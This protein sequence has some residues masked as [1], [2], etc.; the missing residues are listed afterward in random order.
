MLSRHKRAAAVW[1]PLGLG[2]LLLAAGATAC[3][4]DP[5]ASSPPSPRVAPAFSF[6]VLKDRARELAAKPYQPEPGAELPDFLKRLN[7]DQYQSLRFRPEQGPW[8]GERLPFSIQFFHRGYLFQDPVRIYLVDAGQVQDFRFSPQ[9]F[10][11][12]QNQ[13]PKPVPPDLQFAGLRVLYPVNNPSKQDEVA[14]FIGASYFRL[15]GAH[16]R[17]GAAGRGL[18]I[19]TAEPSGEEF[20][21][22]TEF[23]IEKPGQSANYLQLFA[24]LDSPSVTGAW[25]FVIKPGEAT[26]LEVEASIFL[27][28]EVKKL[29]LAPLTSMMLI[30][31]NHIRCIPDFRPEVHDSDGLLLRHGAE[32]WLWRPLINPE[33]D[34]QVSDFPAQELKGF[35]LL[36]RERDFHDYQDLASRYEVRPSLWVEPR[37]TWG[38]GALE[39]VEIPTPSE[40][41]DNIVAYWVAKDTPAV[42]QEFHWTYSLTASL[43]DPPRPPLLRVLNT[44]INPEHDK[45]PPRFVI[46]FTGDSLPS[47]AASAPVAANVQASH[48]EF[49]NV[50][51]EKNEV[52]GGW[53]TF[54]DL[55]GAG[56][57]PA[58]LR[59]FLHSGDLVL[60][61]TWVY[62][63]RGP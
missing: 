61:E 31:A 11:Y 2:I 49:R 58:E 28:K 20:P 57:Q 16:Q 36:Q 9:Q 43:T 18:A 30:G 10:D 15:I 26:E 48:G 6:S 21:R 45:L 42:G 3:L 39:L 5:V 25:R 12:G 17:Y 34:H 35:G 24:L 53:R 50:V 62:H 56:A 55:A 8:K 38:R 29:G 51:I 60:S 13:F 46:D 1:L 14:T 40:G 22:F 32:Q 37:D 27:R 44:R 33:K 23:W 47:L 4:A 59:L 63:Y 7:Y 54:F 19:N 52:T 41:N